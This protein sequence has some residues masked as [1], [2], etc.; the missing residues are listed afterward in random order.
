MVGTEGVSLP[1]ENIEI[2][3]LEIP[4]KKKGNLEETTRKLATAKYLQRE[5]RILVSQLKAT[6]N[7]WA[8]NTFSL[9][10]I[11]YHAGMNWP[12]KEMAKKEIETTDK[13]T[14]KLTQSSAP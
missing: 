2:I 10:V 11:R 1:N 5:R 7:G 6:K 9:P 13:K 14:S 12:K 4:Q 3:Y 8:I